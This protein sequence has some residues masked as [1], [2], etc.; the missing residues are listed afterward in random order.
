M[1]RGAGVTRGSTLW[2]LQVRPGV[3]TT[4]RGWWAFARREQPGLRW[5]FTAARYA[6]SKP[7]DAAPS[8]DTPS[9]Y[10]HRY[11][12]SDAG[13]FYVLTPAPT[14]TLGEARATHGVH[15]QK[16]PQ[17]DVLVMVCKY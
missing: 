16:G 12:T 9:G 14:A 17:V 11:G 10:S 6:R 1:G 4:A 2:G 13:A 3:G 5:G 15:P 8:R 7:A